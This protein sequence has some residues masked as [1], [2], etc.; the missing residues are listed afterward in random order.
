MVL[1]FA[2]YKRW[3]T[4]RR[5]DTTTKGGNEEVSAALIRPCSGDEPG[6]F[7]ALT[8]VLRC[9]AAPPLRV[10][11]GVD[12]PD[13]GAVLVIRRAMAAL[14]AAGIESRLVV[15]PVLGPNRKTSILA[16]CVRKADVREP[17]IISAD[18]NTDLSGFDLSTL[19]S[20]L[21]DNRGAAAVWSPPR[22]K[23]NSG[24]AGKA[25]LHASWHSFGLLSAIDPAGMVGKLFAVRRDALA[26][27]GGFESFV[28]YLGEDMA[29][30]KRLRA[31]G[32]SVLP[33]RNSVATIGGAGGWRETVARHTRW[34]MVI[35]AQ[36]PRLILSY[37]LLFFSSVFVYPLA[38]FAS[39]TYPLAGIICFASA[40]TVRI[41]VGYTAGR[42]LQLRTPIKRIVLE[43]VLSDAVLL[44]A[45]LS[46]LRK[47]TVVWR[48]REFSF[49]AHGT[50]EESI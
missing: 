22:L 49:D 1:L 45:F 7:D 21:T 29:L 12:K 16:G 25:V 2:V 48:G 5:F 44:F 33:T 30:S 28:R 14:D 11:F 8:S 20:M 46:T 36:R 50:L 23:K 27:V 37:P 15:T 31:R 32:L 41:L 4:R 39:I 3:R 40:A 47:Q 35:K 34:M 10:I 9:A 42:M 24:M 43:T 18:S 19:V 6:L 13:D 38:L 17:V 26:S